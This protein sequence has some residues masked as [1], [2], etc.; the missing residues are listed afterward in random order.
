M[1]DSVHPLHSDRDIV[2]TMDE[3]YDDEVR[4]DFG[5]L[6]ISST[7]RPLNGSAFDMSNLAKAIDSV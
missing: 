5:E 6:T 7:R 2:D 4:I 1:C 3:V